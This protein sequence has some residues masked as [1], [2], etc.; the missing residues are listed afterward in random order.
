MT[1]MN[2][3]MHM[4]SLTYSPKWWLGTG[5]A[6]ESMDQDRLYYSVHIAVLLKRW[7]LEDAQGN[8]YVYGGPGYY[9]NR[10]NGH[11]VDEGG[12]GR[13]G[14]QVDYETRRIYTAARYVER[15]TFDGFNKLDDF[16]EL[17]LG[18]AP[19]IANYTEL[20]SWLIVR[21]M[22]NTTTKDESVVPTLR[23]FYKTF[24]WEVGMSMQGRPQLNFMAIF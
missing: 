5:V 6:M 8:F 3:N 21:Y 1:D 14:L 7:N 10:F 24:L 12:F 11:I 19:Y 22:A 15:R 16:L 9:T 18:F 13:M 2:E 4:T 23:F 17:G 20:N